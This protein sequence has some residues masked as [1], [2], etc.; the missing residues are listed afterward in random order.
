MSLVELLGGLLRPAAC[1]ACGVPAAWRCCARCLPPEPAGA[2]PWRLAADPGVTLWALGPYRDAL[3][4]A[5]LAGKLRGQPA[6][7]TELGRR[8]GAA[9]AAA[10][11]GADLVTFVAAGRAA[12]TPRDHAERVAA[13]V[14]AALD[15]PLAGLLA[16]TG[17]RDL[18]RARLAGEATPTR[19]APRARRRLAG[20]RV[21][22]V[23]DLATTGG[24]RAAAAATLRAA[25]ARQVEAAVLGA[26]PTAL[27]PRM[28]A[29]RRPASAPRRRPAPAVTGAAAPRGPPS[30][31]GEAG[32]PGSIGLAEPARG[33]VLAGILP[34]HGGRIVWL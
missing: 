27:G 13:G 30:A 5:V 28:P 31:V 1:L 18:G 26:A 14:A 23:D 16:A 25:G 21:L 32:P 24:T 4:T 10:G 34:A 9:M 7:L 2:G 11:A 12:G 15:L 29:L 22:V 6:A 8:L 3:R 19:P 20:G 17:G 33:A